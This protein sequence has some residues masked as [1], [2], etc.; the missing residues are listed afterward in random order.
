MNASRALA[1]LLL[2]AAPALA[3]APEESVSPLVSRAL[4]GVSGK[5][6]TAV[7]VT[8]PPGGRA[9][10]HRHGSA[11]LYAHV[12]EG[13]VRSQL[14]GEPIRTY[15][16]GQGWTEDPGAHHLLTENASDSVPARLLVTFV[17]DEGEPLKTEDP[18][19]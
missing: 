17:S 11:F 4:P 19:R 15:D 14:E 10:P 9:T 3:A 12:L 2:A 5:R 1:L 16:T 6:F 18:G 13:R 8:F 7:I